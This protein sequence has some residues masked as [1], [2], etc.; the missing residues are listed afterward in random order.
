MRTEVPRIDTIR[1]TAV[2]V[3]ENDLRIS[4]MR[5]YAIVHALALEEKCVDGVRITIHYDP[6][7][8]PARVNTG[9]WLVDCACE[10]GALAEP[11]WPEVRCF[12]CGAVMVPIFP[13][14]ADIE[15]LERLLVRRPLANRHWRPGETLAEVEA[16]NAR[17]G[18]GGSHAV[19]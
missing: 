6:I 1:T 2:R 12:H 11:E 3:G 5:E 14:K 9:R 10:A 13:P 7:G 15:A 17:H 16:D 19:E 4:S 18:L 8:R